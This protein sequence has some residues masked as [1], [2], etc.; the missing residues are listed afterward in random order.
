MT[1]RI[2]SH[3]LPKQIEYITSTADVAIYD[4][5][6]G[7]GKTIANVS[8]AIKLAIEYPGI[9]I[10]VAAPTY[11]ML[12]D[13]ILFEFR[14]RC[15]DVLL[16][17][18]QTALRGVYP[19]AVFKPKNGAQS[20]VR[21]RAFNDIGKPKSITVG[22]L[23]V[24]EVTE[25]QD[26]VRA[27]LF[28]RVRQTGMP[29]YIRCTTN[30][31]S[32]SHPFYVQFI[33]PAERGELPIEQLHR[34][35]AT[36]YDNPTLPANYIRQL[37][38]LKTNRPGEYMRMVLG[39]WGDFDDST[40]GA[41]DMVP[42]FSSPYLVAFLD[43][44][45]SD[46]TVSDRTALSIVGFV[47]QDGIENRFWPIEFTGKAWQKSITN[48]QVIYEMLQFLDRFRPIEVCVESQLGD[49][50]QIF[51]DRFRE[52]ERDLQ[53]SPR[54][55]WTVL[56]QTKNKHARIM[57]NVAGN[58]DRIKVLADTE[59]EYLNPIVSYTKKAEHDDEIDSLAGAINLW[60]TSP[61]L[62]EYI[63]RAERMRI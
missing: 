31:D 21:F 49:S 53:L 33:G 41:F 63:M 11:G 42:A 12:K 5:G 19:N 37:E 48:T 40:I 7:A 62:Q 35:H 58:K 18:R 17:P 47:P 25:M 27:E 34:I 51:L 3:L 60:R 15:P 1:I 44:S 32:K 50:T 30:P 16:D 24:D 61:N 38:M 56:H 39:E 2:R 55:H 23:I 45:F 6:V 28:R 57:F 20:T 22:A 9:D 26:G 8:L 36:T 4:G 29:N 43:T 13:T 54:N 46:S 59:A 52:A 10:L 14:N